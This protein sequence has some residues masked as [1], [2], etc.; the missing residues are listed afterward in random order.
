MAASFTNES[1]PAKSEAPPLA[2]SDALVW[3]QGAVSP[4][5]S[6]APPAQNTHF[7]RTQID[8]QLLGQMIESEPRQRGRGQACSQHAERIVAQ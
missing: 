2:H 3:P 7:P 5:R 1:A 6:E 8:C 4:R